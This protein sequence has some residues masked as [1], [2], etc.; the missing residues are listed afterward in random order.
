MSLLEQYEAYRQLQVK[1]HSEILDKCVSAE[2]FNQ[3]NAM[4]GVMKSNEIVLKSHYEK[5]VILDF[6]VY[7]KYKHNRNAVSRY[8]DLEEELTTKEKTLLAAM[9][10]SYTSLFEIV[11]YHAGEG[12]IILRNLLHDSDQHLTLIDMDFSK[13]I[14]DHHLLFTR[15]IDLGDF[16]LTSGLGF[17]FNQNHQQYVLKRSKKLMKKVNSGDSSIDRFIAFFYLNRSDGIVTVFQTLNQ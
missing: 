17:V 12:R 2:D 15:I 1:L 16:C 13:S 8:I 14:I 5:D 7:E 6:N 10:K 11:D 3:V 4:I 9:E